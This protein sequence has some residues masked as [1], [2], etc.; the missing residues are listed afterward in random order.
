MSDPRIGRRDL[1]SLAALVPF[2]VTPAIGE[3]IVSAA[4]QSTPA[5]RRAELYGLLGDLPARQRPISGRQRSETTRDGFVL[6]TWD[7]DLNGFENVPAYYARP[8]GATGRIPAIV[9]NHSHGGGYTIGKTEL[10]EGR[11]YLQPEPYAK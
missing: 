11:T 4:S 5:S 8:A 2:A 3:P 6:E 1:L 10:L 9:F 7:L